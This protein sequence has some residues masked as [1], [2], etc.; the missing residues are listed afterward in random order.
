[1]KGTTNTRRQVAVEDRLPEPGAGALADKIL[2]EYKA[3]TFRLGDFSWDEYNESLEREFS[4][5]IAGQLFKQSW[6]ERGYYGDMIRRRATFG[7]RI[8]LLADCRRA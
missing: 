7:G 1:V 8:E 4:N 3:D 5:G 6:L 2:G